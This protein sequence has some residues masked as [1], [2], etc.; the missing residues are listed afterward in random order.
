LNNKNS[1]KQYK[2]DFYARSLFNLAR[3]ENA[4]DRVEDEM[5]QLKSEI[6]NNLELKKYL[7]D[8][9]IPAPE[10]IKSMLG[11]LGEDASDAVKAAISTLIIMNVL[12]SIEQIYRDYVA[13][14]NQLK[15]QVSIEVISAVELD[16]DTID[17]IKKDVDDKT[18]LDVRIKNII[19]RDIIG[20][21]VIKIG[22]RIIDL[23]LKNKIDDL[24]TKL[25]ALELRGEDFGIEN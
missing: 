19:D 7:T 10:K 5:G 18:D 21:I 2:S 13:L 22:D 8:S 1:E 11:I 6:L 3:A 17:T 24:K 14:A 9:S 15:K 23:S 16:S 4:V 25:K 12:E 20:G